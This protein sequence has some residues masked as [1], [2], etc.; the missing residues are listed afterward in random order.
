MKHNKR[1]FT[2]IELLVVVLIIGILAAVALPQYQIAVAKARMA[3]TLPVLKAMIQAQKSYKLA[4]DQ[5]A[6]SF[7]TLDIDLPAGGTF[8][9]DKTIMTY[10]DGRKYDL[11]ADSEGTAC[12]VRAWSTDQT[13]FF[14]LYMDYTLACYARANNAF[15]NK[16]C[17]SF[18]GK[19]GTTSGN[20]TLYVLTKDT[21]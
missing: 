16:V 8:N 18:A 20:Y 11:W 9:N 5:Y 14:E 10:S 15:A 7:E 6:S 13:Y 19:D 21:L 1:A 3:T 17:K 2:L 4:N 12:S